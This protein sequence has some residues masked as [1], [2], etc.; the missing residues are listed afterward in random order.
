MKINKRLLILSVAVITAILLCSCSR[1]SMRSA[2]D[3]V[4][5]TTRRA[6]NF[7]DNGLNSVENRVENGRNTVTDRGAYGAN[8]NY[9]GNT[10]T[11]TNTMLP[12]DGNASPILP[13][14]RDRK[15]DNI[16]RINTNRGS[17]DGG[18]R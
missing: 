14:L 16:G 3:A 5:N 2:G 4:R 11:G 1:G 13:T 17:L 9:S 15:N 18:T 12:Y 6:E 8:D 7:M 10:G